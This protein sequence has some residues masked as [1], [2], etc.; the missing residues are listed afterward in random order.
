ME[1]G[2]S[3]LKFH[4]G[5][6]V[7]KMILLCFF[8]LSGLQSTTL[9]GPEFTLQRFF[10]LSLPSMIDVGGFFF[11]FLLLDSEKNKVLLTDKLN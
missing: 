6:E 10:T 9:G 1:E 8:K 11:F 4:N 5:F 2:L 3:F 7:F